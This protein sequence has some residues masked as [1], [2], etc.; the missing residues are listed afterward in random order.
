MHTST[1]LEAEHFAY[2]R[3][4]ANSGPPAA[5]DFAACFPNYHYQDRLGV[6]ALPYEYGALYT[7]FALLACT[8]AFYDALRSR[9]G[10]FFDYPQ[11]YLFFDRSAEGVNTTAGRRRLDQDA[12]GL[13]GHLD[14][15]PEN[16]WVAAPSRV[17]GIIKT[18]FD[19]N[20]NRLFWPYG[21]QPEAGEAKLPWYA[22][23]MLRT[24]LK[25]VYYYNSPRPNIEIRGAAPA[26]KLVWETIARL[27]SITDPPPRRSGPGARGRDVEG[28][29]QVEVETFLASLDTI[30]A[31]KP[32]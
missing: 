1:V 22:H 3:C 7:G 2:F 4:S 24:R 5:S 6:V 25:G 13:M 28:Y 26:E 16:K 19:Y 18:I 23:K 11:H 30:F 31:Q 9:D 29:E 12:L 27:Q 20:I 21:L 10:A 32:G 8:T 14:V 15:W 17:S